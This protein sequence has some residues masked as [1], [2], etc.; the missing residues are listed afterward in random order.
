MPCTL[1]ECFLRAE[2]DGERKT[3]LSSLRKI[4]VNGFEKELMSAGLLQCVLLAYLR[5]ET[6]ARALEEMAELMVPHVM[7]LQNVQEGV[8]AMVRLVD[9]S[10]RFQNKT[11]KALLKGLADFVVT[12]SCDP[13]SVLLV[14]RLLEVENFT[15]R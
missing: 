11:R 13:H 8:M 4:L 10:V 1:E 3:Y 2:S 15:F 6:S 14:I 7:Q 5:H 12:M 9:V